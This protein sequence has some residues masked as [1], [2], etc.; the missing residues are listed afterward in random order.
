MIDHD[1]L[2]NVLEIYKY[3]SKDKIAGAAQ[4]AIQESLVSNNVLSEIERQIL[5]ETRKYYKTKAQFLYANVTLVD[6]LK[7]AQRFK[8]D[9]MIRCRRYLVWEKMEEKV[10][11]EFQDEVI[12]V[13]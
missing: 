2:K 10:I 3:L 1:L 5:S 12:V 11:A 9:E 7:S 13:N 6:Y 4:V 8:N